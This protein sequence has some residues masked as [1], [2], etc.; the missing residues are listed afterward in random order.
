MPLPLLIYNLVLILCS[1]LILASYL[2]KLYR[3]PDYRARWS[4]RLGQFPPATQT[5]GLHIHAVSL[6]EAKVA[7][8]VVDALRNE[9]PALPVIFTCST[10]TAS[11][12]IRNKYAD[13]I[14]HCHL[15]LDFPWLV[16][17]FIRRYQPR[18]CV[19]TE[20][21]WW[22]NLIGQYHRRQT[23]IVLI[24][25]KM[26]ASSAQTYTKLGP[27]F[28][29]MAAGITQVLAQNQS[30]FAQFQQLGLQ[31]QQL[32]LANNIKFDEAAPSAFP[33]AI[34]QIRDQLGSRPVWIAGSTHADDEDAIFSA[35]ATVKAQI[36]E[37]LLILVP[38]H[39]ERFKQVADRCQQA[40]YQMVRRSD[41]G[42]PDGDTDILLGDTLGELV[43]L[44]SLADVAFVGGSI[45]DRGGHN[46]LEAAIFGIPILMGPSQ[47][48]AAEI[49]Q[50]LIDAG[51]LKVIHDGESL[52][53]SLLCWLQDETL[54]QQAGQQSADVINANQ[55]AL[56]L[57]TRYLQQQLRP[58][59]S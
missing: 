25:A 53:E 38:R 23:P 58:S 31:P 44:Y 6:G 29:V 22:P 45:T 50:R 24:N 49:S 19:I 36:P 10:A 39:P 52:S 4:E 20:V 2:I 57:T 48:N 54:R 47:Y 51:A 30:S 18:L 56:G 46:P 1:P 16:A 21:E 26:N 12:F 9:D 15:P 43:S 34:E 41:S 55:G 17:R 40:G 27:L 13:S 33:E 7:A 32:Q 35:F 37:L 28:R 8:K 59:Q 14:D 11:D 42:L 3:R 5:G